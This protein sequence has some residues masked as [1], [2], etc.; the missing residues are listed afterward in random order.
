MGP[1]RPTY[2]LQHRH[3][4]IH[5]SRVGWDAGTEGDPWALA[6]SIHPSRVG[7]DMECSSD[8]QL[9]AHFNPPI[10]CGMGL[11][12][13]WTT[14]ILST[15]QSTHPVWDGTKGGVT[16]L[17]DGYISIHPSRVGWD[18]NK[19]HSLP[20]HCYFN[21][22]IPCGMGPPAPLNTPA[23]PCYF[24]PPIPCGM[25]HLA[26]EDTMLSRRISIHPSRVGW[27]EKT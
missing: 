24:N 25:G 18:G 15:F 16:I 1:H 26:D 2:R 20:H 8:E 3:I 12:A 22:P 4:S 23:T 6:I 11:G 10:P 19:S 5:P 7:W 14:A 27:D 13:I 17:R 21:P 9:L